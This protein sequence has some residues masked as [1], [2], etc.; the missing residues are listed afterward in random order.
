MKLGFVL[1]TFVALVLITIVAVNAAPLGLRGVFSEGFQTDNSVMNL[2]LARANMGKE[3]FQG[4]AVNP[5][6]IPPARPQG[7]TT[8]TTKV[9]QNMPSSV[10]TPTNMPTTVPIPMPMP[11]ATTTTTPPPNA[12]MMAMQPSNPQMRQGQTRSFE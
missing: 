8:T 9:G 10:S 2:K 5:V 11:T 3:G 4:T 12:A 1:S 7:I 6:V